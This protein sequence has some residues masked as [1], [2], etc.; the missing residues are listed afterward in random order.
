MCGI[1]GMFRAENGGIGGILTTPGVCS[2]C[3]Y[4]W[5]VLGREWRHFDHTRCLFFFLGNMRWRF[6]MEDSLATPA[7]AGVAFFCAFKKHPKR[8]LDVFFRQVLARKNNSLFACLAVLAP[9]FVWCVALKVLVAHTHRK[10]HTSA[11]LC[12]YASLSLTPPLPPSPPPSLPRARSLSSRC[13]THA[14]LSVFRLHP[15]SLALSLTH[16]CTCAEDTRVAAT[17]LGKVL[18]KA[19]DLF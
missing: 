5:H 6:W 16:A 2:F 11:R 1:C 14:R 7:C 17:W 15:L 4:F 8:L 18:R 10:K 19:Q 9:L 12:I 3:W 13:L